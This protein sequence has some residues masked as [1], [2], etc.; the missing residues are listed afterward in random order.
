MDPL[1]WC[2]SKNVNSWRSVLYVREIARWYVGYVRQCMR[3]ITITTTMKLMKLAGANIVLVYSMVDTAVV[4]GLSA[5][6]TALCTELTCTMLVR[7][8]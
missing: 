7:N 8:S 3:N 4:T 2:V 6:S 1:L 5:F